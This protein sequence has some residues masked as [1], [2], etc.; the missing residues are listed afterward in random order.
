[1]MHCSIRVTHLSVVFTND[2][3]LLL[4]DST[5]CKSACHYNLLRLAF[6]AKSSTYDSSTREKS[7]NN[8]YKTVPKFDVAKKTVSPVVSLAQE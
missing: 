7:G 3:E 2:D 8:C 6:K 5:I 4:N 1:M